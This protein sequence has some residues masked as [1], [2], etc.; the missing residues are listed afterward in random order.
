VQDKVVKCLGLV[1]QYNPLTVAPG[2]LSK[3]DDCYIRR[4]NIIEDRRGYK[5]YSLFDNPPSAILNYMN[6]VLVHEGSSVRY[7][8]GSGTFSAYSGSY[9]SPSGSRIRGLEAFSNLYTTTS[10]GVKVFSNI[11]GTEARLAGAPRA[12]DPSYTLTGGSGFLSDDSQCAYRCVIRVTDDNDNVITGYPSQR[13]W[14]ANSAGGSRNVALTVYLPSAC[15]A[16]DVVQFYRTEQVSGVTTDASGDEMGLVYQYELS[17]TD[18]SSGYITFTDSVTDALR[19]ATLYTSPSQEGIGQANAIPPLSKDIA[20][21]KSNYMLYANTQTKQR[22]TVTLVGTS[23]LSS[24]TITLGGVTYNFGASEI[25]SGAGSP[26]ANVSATGVAAVDID[27]TARSLVRVI[28]RYAGNTSIYAYYL[29][30]P[31]DL[32][33]AIMI[34]ERGIGASA[35]TLQSS[36]ATISGMFFPQPPVSPATSVKSTSSNQ[37]QKNAI[38]Y[39]KSQ[40]PEHCPLLNYLLVGPSNEEILRVIALRDSA[41]VIKEKGV[42]RITGETPQSFTVVPVDLTVFCKA[43]ESIVVLANQ[44]YM[45]SNQGVV[46]ISESGVQVVSHEIEQLLTP[47]L[48]SSTLSTYTAACGYESERSYFLSTITEDDDAQATQTFVFNTF[49]K[50]WVRH[51]YAFTA[52]LV[53]PTTDKLF[54]SKPADEKLYVER[55]SF[56]DQDY[57]DPEH[58]ITITAV[59]ETTVDFEVSGATPQVGWVIAQSTSEIPISE[60]EIVGDAYRA[61]META[62]P[63]DWAAGAATI[64]PAV[65]MNIEWHPYTAGAPNAIKQTSEAALLSDDSLNDSSAT[66]LE[67]RFRSNFIPE[68]EEVPIVQSKEGWGAAWGTSPWGGGGDPVGYRTWVPRE[69]QYNSRLTVGVRHLYARQ[70]LVIA[71][72]GFLSNGVSERIGR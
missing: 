17:S 47:L 52:A 13:L 27:L 1:A 4:E 46:S 62:V 30:G 63:S 36:D 20:L 28:N 40:Q 69:M 61:T 59:T 65:G 64:Y 32:P 10:L 70:K 7:D 18:I 22:L 45:L 25:V 67:F 53:E 14:A 5:E 12:L 24:K 34:E 16:G 66:A 33:G 48:L 41:I 29:S 15:V 3:A 60:L 35:F 8:D 50:T 72:I 68:F 54:F 44:V 71:G 42:Y 11:T 21:Y 38:Y 19:G 43:V 51:T 6:R 23:G 31:D 56:S 37:I 2:A 9:S 49:T 55:K 39:A 57:A 58:T 26:Q